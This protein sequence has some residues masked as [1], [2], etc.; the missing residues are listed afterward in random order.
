MSISAKKICESISQKGME[1]LE[2]DDYMKAG[3]AILMALFAIS[4]SPAMNSRSKVRRGGINIL[5]DSL[6]HD[7]SLL[8]YYI[9]LKI[10]N[11]HKLARFSDNN[12][13]CEVINILKRFPLPRALDIITDSFFLMGD[14]IFI[15]SEIKND[16]EFSVGEDLHDIDVYMVD[17]LY[18]DLSVKELMQAMLEIEVARNV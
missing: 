17:Y 12:I 9:E 18:P 14:F 16:V 11:M 2:S 7:L 5:V 15:Q 1:Y 3:T 13:D 6:G 4:K 8:P 10:D